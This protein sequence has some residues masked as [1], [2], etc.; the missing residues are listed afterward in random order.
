MQ[1]NCSRSHLAVSRYC[2]VLGTSELRSSQDL[3]RR[4][5]DGAVGEDQAG[6]AMA[7]CYTSG[8]RMNVV[9]CSRLMEVAAKNLGD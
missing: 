7:A 2:L 1:S 5:S 8:E 6:A 4:R 9:T 3:R